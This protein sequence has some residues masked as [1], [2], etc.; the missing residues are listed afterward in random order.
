MLQMLL[1][2]SMTLEILQPL[3]AMNSQPQQM[4]RV[5][6]CIEML[7]LTLQKLPLDLGQELTP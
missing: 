1:K 4:L 5:V 2:N 6:I 7:F 3:L